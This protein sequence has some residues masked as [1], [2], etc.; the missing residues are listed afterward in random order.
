MW[1]R[2]LQ[3]AGIVAAVPVFCYKTTTTVVARPY[4]GRLG[5]VG[6]GH[7][8]VPQRG[9]AE[10]GARRLAGGLNEDP[11]GEVGADFVERDALL[12]AGVA[13]AHRDGLVFGGVAV[14]GEAERAA[15][16]VH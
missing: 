3:S 4:L 7:E 11:L 13:F 10:P 16:F 6:A 8:E 9:V 2:K 14:D 15:G 1:L 12:G 5:H